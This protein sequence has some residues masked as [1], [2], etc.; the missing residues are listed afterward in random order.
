MSPTGYFT[1]DTWHE[2]VEDAKDAAHRL[3]GVPPEALT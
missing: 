2:T 3:F 1:A